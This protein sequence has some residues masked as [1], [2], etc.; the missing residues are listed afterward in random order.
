VPNVTA[1]HTPDDNQAGNI[2]CNAVKQVQKR[3]GGKRGKI[4]RKR[5]AFEAEI[6]AFCK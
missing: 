3:K 2:I 5:R 4:G 6:K 1:L